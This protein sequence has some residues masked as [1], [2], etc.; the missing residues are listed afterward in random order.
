M[1]E[2]FL[3]I[4]GGGKFGQKS[5]DYA[6]KN[7]F[8]TI[9]IDMD[10]NCYASKFI[11]QRFQNS[12]ELYDNLSNIKS[13]DIAFLNQDVIV[14]CELLER[15]KAEY[16][17]PVVPIHLMGKIIENFLNKN[18]IKL[19]PNEKVLK[20]FLKIA[21]PNLVLNN[22][23]SLGTAY[24]SYAKMED[25]CPDMCACP[26]KYCSNFKREKP[27]TITEYIKNLYNIENI[28]NIVKN[29]LLEISVLLNSYQ[30]TPGLGGIKADEIHY[31]LKILK[32]KIEALKKEK[33]SMSIATT[34]NCHGVINF[35]RT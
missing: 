20:N 18:S 26:P 35:Y 13:Q 12:E 23:P 14:V 3:I 4:A 2:E 22:I 27:V 28:V 24:L 17:I 6:K 9:L 16:I 7:K 19:V 33:F 34:C 11:T 15:V 5:I 1:K 21:D 8:K 29:D 10:P 32:Q 31:V 30:L 25:I